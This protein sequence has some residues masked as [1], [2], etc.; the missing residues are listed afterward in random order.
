MKRLIAIIMSL[1]VCL[2]ASGSFIYAAELNTMS[3]V[4]DDDVIAF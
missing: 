4:I 3:A 2:L 1:C